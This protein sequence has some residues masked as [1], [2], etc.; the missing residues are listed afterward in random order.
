MMSEVVMKV[1]AMQEKLY[2]FEVGGI[3]NFIATTR[4]I[5]TIGTDITIMAILTVWIVNT[6]MTT[7]AIMA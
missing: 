5:V 6:I 4:V 7:S 2:E 1:E 3:L